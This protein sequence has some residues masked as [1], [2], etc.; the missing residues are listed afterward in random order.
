MIYL[1]KTSKALEQTN[2]V[3]HGFFG[4]KGGVSTGEYDSLNLS[5][6]TGDKSDKV[7]KNRAI[8]AESL[9]GGP[10]VTLKQVHSTRV[11][12]VG[13][14]PLPD[15]TI[16]ADALVTT[17]RNILLGVLTA[18]CAPLLLVDPGAAIIGAAHAGWAGAVN[19]MLGN[20]VA[21]MEALG[22]NRKHIHLAIGPTI[23]GQNYEVGEEFRDK[24]VAI[25]PASSNAFF[26]PEG[27]KPH[28]D[29]PAFLV[30]DAQRLGLMQIDNL[31]LCTYAR[32]QEFFSHRYATHQG[33]Q[34]GR[35]ISVIGLI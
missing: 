12:T 31:G 15:S 26:T 2:S 33:T 10:L 25:N 27:G 32:P 18:D 5:V 11:V 35:Q 13:D 34:T 19:G 8:I 20:T 29:L 23:S 3:R 22:A 7:E 21:A 17:R 30:A 6:S 14:G 4:R 24:A 28:F 1:A 16:E 9:G